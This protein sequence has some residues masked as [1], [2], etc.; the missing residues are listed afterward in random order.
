M[1]AHCLSNWRGLAVLG[2]ACA[3]MAPALAAKGV[4]L[5]RVH[6]LSYSDDGQRIMNPSHQGLAVHPD[7]PS[8]AALG[9]ATGLYLSRDFA[10]DFERLASGYQVLGQTFD[11]DDQHLWFSAFAGKPLLM[12]IKLAVGASAETVSLPPLTQDAVAYIAQNPVRPQE[13]AIATFKRNVYISRDAGRN[14]QAIA[15]DGATRQAKNK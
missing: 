12:R 13:M 10:A 6:G 2:L 15:I 5:T 9:T 7:D 8:I 11:L 4:H 1:Q 14:W 3:L